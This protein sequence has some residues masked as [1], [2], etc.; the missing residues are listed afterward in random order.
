MP[1]PK[2][3]PQG[4]KKK[5]KGGAS[6]SSS[7]SSTTATDASAYPKSILPDPKSPGNCKLII[8]VK[9][10]SKE[11]TIEAIDDEWVSVHIAEEAK[12][13]K[14][15][16]ELLEYLAEVLNIKKRDIDLDKGSRSH[17]KLFLISGV[18]PTQAY[19]RLQSG[20]SK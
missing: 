1:F 18:T 10:N 5:G 7:S 8:C 17:N 20:M 13:G 4:N 16:A 2:K 11:N 19:Q 3:P 9:P 14:A 15:N 6:S 12:D